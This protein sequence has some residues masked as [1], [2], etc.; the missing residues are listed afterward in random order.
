MP[1]ERAVAARAAAN[2]LVPDTQTVAFATGT[3]A[4]TV[5]A[6]INEVFVSVA[7]DVSGVLTI[8]PRPALSQLIVHLGDPGSGDV[9]VNYGETTVI[10]AGP[11]INSFDCVLVSTGSQMVTQLPFAMLIDYIEA[12]SSSS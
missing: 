12:A 4:A 5:P 1:T 11:D 9:V 10:A 8:A 2:Q 7:D 3:L 6:H